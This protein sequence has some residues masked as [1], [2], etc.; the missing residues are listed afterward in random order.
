MKIKLTF[1]VKVMTIQ[2]QKMVWILLFE[3]E[4]FQIFTICYQV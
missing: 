3:L 1:E 2:M 4:I